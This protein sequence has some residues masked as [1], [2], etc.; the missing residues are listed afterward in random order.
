MTWLT[1][2]EPTPSLLLKVVQSVPDN[3]PV[4]RKLA[5]G[6]LMTKALVVVV[7]LKMLPAVPVL[8]LLMMLATVMLVLDCKFLEASV[9]TKVL[10]VK[11]ARLKVP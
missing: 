2:E 10:P 8:T 4:V 6:M 5:V 1:A 3:C 7:M 9:V 11:V